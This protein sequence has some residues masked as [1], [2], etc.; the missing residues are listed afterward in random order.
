LKKKNEEDFDVKNLFFIKSYLLYKF[1][2]EI[3]KNGFARFEKIRLQHSEIKSIIINGILIGVL[4]FG[5]YMISQYAIESDEPIYLIIICNAIFLV[6]LVGVV[7][8][9]NM[10]IQ[11]YPQ[12]FPYLIMIIYLGLS[13]TEQVAFNVISDQYSLNFLV[14]QILIL[15]SLAYPL[16]FVSI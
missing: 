14:Q 3:A 7:Y 12:Q 10:L 11:S 15:T 16:Y 5:L 1:N 6:L 2:D 9:T 13:I 8:R 4:L